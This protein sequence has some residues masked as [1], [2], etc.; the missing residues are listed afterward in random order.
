MKR[1]ARTISAPE[2][3]PWISHDFAGGG[4]DFFKVRLCRHDELA[5]YPLIQTGAN[6][7]DV[8][9]APNHILEDILRGIP[10][11]VAEDDIYPQAN[12]GGTW[13]A[14]A[15]LKLDRV[16][17]DVIVSPADYGEQ[18]EIDWSLPHFVK[19][20]AEFIGSEAAWTPIP[21]SK[22]GM[23]KQGGK[24]GGG[25]ANG[26]WA[27]FMPTK[28]SYGDQ[29]YS[30]ATRHYI[31]EYSLFTWWGEQF[32]S[33]CDLDEEDH[34]VHLYDTSFPVSEDPNS[35]GPE[36]GITTCNETYAGYTIYYW[37]PTGSSH[38]RVVRKVGWYDTDY[39][40]G[41]DP[42]PSG[43]GGILIPFFADLLH[44]QFNLPFPG[45]KRKRPRL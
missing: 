37:N 18:S 45:N 33:G 9:E 30:F 5:N 26:E 21:E 43:G 42:I 17:A 1:G 24:S 22:T 7:M 44:S 23:F 14:P 10:V 36:C 6:W 34:I 4:T 38:A 2:T 20:V 19:A 39:Y 11:T 13:Q 31:Y 27:V 29:E 40:P 3:T 35:T 15:D 8:E 28:T 25:G 41:R 32:Y 16:T 12:L